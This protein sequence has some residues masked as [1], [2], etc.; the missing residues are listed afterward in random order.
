MPNGKTLGLKLKKILLKF[1][2]GKV[3]S[4]MRKVVV[5]IF[6]LLVG[7]SS[8]AFAIKDGKTSNSYSWTRLCNS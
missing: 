5:L 2:Y 1:E 3:G 7:C 4:I 6:A 8:F